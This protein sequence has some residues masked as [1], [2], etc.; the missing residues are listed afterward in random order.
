M[1]GEQR[2]RLPPGGLLLRLHEA[3]KFAFPQRHA[4]TLIILMMLGVAAINA[5]E[6]LVLKWL[7][8]ELTSGRRLELLIAGVGMLA[9]FAIGRELMDGTANWLSWRTRIGLQYALLE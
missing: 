7:F 1:A 9:G 4:I 2:P 8:D 3:V 6:P 5:V